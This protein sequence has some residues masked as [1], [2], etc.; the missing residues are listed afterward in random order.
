VGSY[1]GSILADVKKKSVF[2]SSGPV[3]LARILERI[4][5]EREVLA[6]AYGPRGSIELCGD[7]T[8]H[9]SRDPRAYKDVYLNF[10]DARRETG[11]RWI[12][13]QVVA[14]KKTR[15]R[16]KAYGWLQ[17]YVARFPKHDPHMA[18]STYP[19]CEQ[20]WR[21]LSD[22]VGHRLALWYVGT[23]FL[24]PELRGYGLGR[25]LYE[26]LLIVAARRRAAIVPDRC[27]TFGTTSKDAMRV[28]ERL[29]Q[30]HPHRGYVVVRSDLL[31]PNR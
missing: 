31:P 19:Q 1:L 2:R 16:P 24:P 22:E 29:V 7:D 12:G 13:F 17:A 3:D 6:T 11:E 18:E 28:W 30:A 15:G 25:L 26:Q 5:G 14:T 27:G 4:H 20:D 9:F 21:A 8:L 10:V 23:T